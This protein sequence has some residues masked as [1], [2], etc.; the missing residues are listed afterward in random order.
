MKV[1]EK[2]LDFNFKN[3]LPIYI[4]L[5][6]QIENAILSGA[7]LEESQIPSTTEVSLAY[8]IN[9]ATVLKSFN[10]LADEKI[11]YKKRGVGMFVASGAV[12]KLNEKRKS[13][14]MSE[15][16]QNL[17]EEAKKLQIDKAKIISMIEGEFDK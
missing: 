14:F 3:D 12:L 16:V 2:A 4:Q 8:K 11:I 7:Y 15:Y 5:A 10:M 13:A 9:P 17:V 6:Q 1:G